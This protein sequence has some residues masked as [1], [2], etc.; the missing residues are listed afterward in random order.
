M[1]NVQKLLNLLLSTS[2]NIR[3]ILGDADFSV[4]QSATPAGTW[5]SI[6]V[7]NHLAFVETPYLKR[8]KRVI[9]EDEPQ[10]TYIHPD[11][12]E[13]EAQSMGSMLQLFDGVRGETVEY[14][15]EL[16]AGAWQRT[17]IHETW[18]RVTLTQLV[19]ALIEHDQEHLNQIK[20]LLEQ[21]A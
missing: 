4:T 21:Q 11:L 6:D 12:L 20:A 2:E 7:I 10:V 3:L 15:K 18:G 14:L 1:K 17:A 13:G 9:E 16:P 8:L 5:Q 19:S